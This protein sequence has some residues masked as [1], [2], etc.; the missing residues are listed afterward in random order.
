MSVNVYF[1]KLIPVKL[2]PLDDIPQLFKIEK[3][4]EEN[5]QRRWVLEA[6]CNDMPALPL[7][8]M[9][10]REKLAAMGTAKLLKLHQTIHSRSLSAY[11]MFILEHDLN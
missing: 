3:Q 5:R 10:I 7:H 9:Y 2:A 4:L 11:F 8:Q 6:I 1:N